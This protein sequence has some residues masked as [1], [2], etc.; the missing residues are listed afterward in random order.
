VACRGVILARAASLLNDKTVVASYC[1]RQK[2]RDKKLPFFVCLL[3]AIGELMAPNQ[4]WFFQVNQ[5]GFDSDQH[6]ENSFLH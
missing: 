4:I 5:K 6:C 2:K 1:T 3:K